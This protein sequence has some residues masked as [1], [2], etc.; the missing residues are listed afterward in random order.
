MYFT[1]VVPSTSY[2]TGRADDFETEKLTTK[3]HVKDF[4]YFIV[5]KD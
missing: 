5:I 1:D 2:G 3:E 4:F